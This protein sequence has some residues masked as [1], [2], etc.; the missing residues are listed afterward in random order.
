MLLKK[1][2]LAFTLVWCLG[3]GALA[4]GSSAG[5][6]EIVKSKFKN[7]LAKDARVEKVA[8]GFKFTEGPVWHPEGYLLF[9]DIPA[10]VIYKYT[11]GETPVVYLENAGFAGSREASNGRGSNGLTFDADGKLLITQ[12][13]ARQ[14]VRMDSEESFTPIARQYMGKRLNSPNDLV[15]HSNGTIYF[16]DPP[17]GLPKGADDPAKELPVQGLYVLNKGNLQLADDSMDK[18]NGVALSPDEDYL[19]VAS[20]EGENKKYYR[21]KVAKDGSLSDRTLFFDA[22]AMGNGSPDGIKVDVKG[23]VYCTGPKGVLVLS[24]N[25][26]LIGIISPA[27]QPANLAWGGPKGKTLYMT[28]RT[29]LYKIEMDVEGIRPQF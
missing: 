16:T 10:N 25:G 4:Q 28:C 18:P 22:S 27:E 9:S 8:D 1:S 11:P 17:Y 5:S 24:D 26:E 7:L 2:F 29:G 19:Y 21:Y 15:A 23:N 6:V 20:R 14:I 12:H 3:Y 13:G